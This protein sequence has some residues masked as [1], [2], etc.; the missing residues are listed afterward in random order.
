MSKY[1]IEEIKRL[2][3]GITPG[4]FCRIREFPKDVYSREKDGHGLIA[5]CSFEADAKFFAASP[6]IVDQLLKENEALEIRAMAA[7][8]CLIGYIVTEPGMN[9]RSA[10]AVANEQ[11]T[12]CIEEIKAWK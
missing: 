7:E 11:V 12:E 5:D 3:D 6:S 4:E 8:D 9:E 1:S 2:R 10:R